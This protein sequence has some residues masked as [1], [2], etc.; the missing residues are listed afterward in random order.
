MRYKYRILHIPTGKILSYSYKVRETKVC[1]KT[2]GHAYFEYWTTAQV[3][4]STL[5]I[6]V[7]VYC[8]SRLPIDFY[9][10]L[11]KKRASSG[12]FFFKDATDATDF[13]RD[14]IL[15]TVRDAVIWSHDYYE[16]KQLQFPSRDEFIVLSAND[17]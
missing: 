1:Q 9:K 3:D 4:Y 16:G 15:T 8:V 17:A 7:S 6:D 10:T 14:F 12:P 13:L 5:G 11:I 2:K